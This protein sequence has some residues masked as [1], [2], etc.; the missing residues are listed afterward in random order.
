MIKSASAKK[1]SSHDAVYQRMLQ[2]GGKGAQYREDVHRQMKINQWAEVS[3][4]EAK[5]HK[6]RHPKHK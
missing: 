5:K 6:K 4:E 3:A 2:R 1:I